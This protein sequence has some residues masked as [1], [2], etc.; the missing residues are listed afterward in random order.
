MT[1]R[2]GPTK[3]GKCDGSRQSVEITAEMIRSAPASIEPS[4]RRQH[5]LRSMRVMMSDHP[6][7]CDCNL[8]FGER[9]TTH[10]GHIVTL[11]DNHRTDPPTMHERARKLRNRA[12]QVNSLAAAQMVM[13]DMCEWMMEFSEQ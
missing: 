3:P 2:Y 1:K 5:Y 8:C 9:V 11:A 6:K 4:I 10:T 12:G 13:R 7:A